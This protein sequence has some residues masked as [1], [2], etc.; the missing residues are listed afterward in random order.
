M[1]LEQVVEV[2]FFCIY[3][4]FADE[5]DVQIVV[6]VVIGDIK[7]CFGDFFKDSGLTDLD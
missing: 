4:K 6:K 7:G 1:R 3:C 5:W 2:I